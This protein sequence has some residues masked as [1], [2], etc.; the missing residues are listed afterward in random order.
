[1]LKYLDSEK[2]IN[3]G[4]CHTVSEKHKKLR[5]AWPQGSF[6]M[7]HRGR[8]GWRGAGPADAGASC[9]PRFLTLERRKTTLPVYRIREFSWIQGTKHFIYRASTETTSDPNFSILILSQVKCQNETHSNFFSVM[10]TK[11]ILVKFC[12]HKKENS[13]PEFQIL[14]SFALC[15]VT[16]RLLL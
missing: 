1:M 8:A 7:Q 3:A 4:R 2:L 16:C 14:E 12:K 15:I 9:T 5:F 13:I 11:C 10:N 6:A